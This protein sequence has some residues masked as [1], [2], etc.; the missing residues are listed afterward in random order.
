MKILVL[1]RVPF[2]FIG[3]DRVIDHTLHEVVYIGTREALATLPDDLLCTRIER[4]AEDDLVTEVRER[5]G[6]GFDRILSM[7]GKDNRAAGQLRA[8]LDVHGAKPHDVQLTEDKLAMKDAV[9]AA[10]LRVPRYA[11][12][13]DVLNKRVT[14]AWHGRTILK[15]I[16]QAGSRGVVELPT[17]EDAIATLRNDP[18]R[19]P[20]T[21]EFEEFIDAPIVH[22]DGLVIGGEPVVLVASRYLGTCLEYVT[23]R[24]QGSVQLDDDHGLCQAAL[25]YLAATGIRDGVFH[26]EMFDHALGPM[27]LEVAKRTGGG[28]IVERIEHTTGINLTAAQIAVELD[29]SPLADNPYRPM[30]EGHPTGLVSGDFLFP[31]H[32]LPSRFCRVV[33]GEQ[34]RFDPRVRRWTERAPDEALSTESS[35]MHFELPLSGVVIGETTAEVEAL[36][37]EILSTVRIESMP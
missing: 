17:V 30:L 10:G 24:P 11:S 15:P 25:P 7:S 18:A 5:V 22:L 26:L 34:L 14:P 4:P 29:T 33:G 21:H 32:K 9:V 28:G 6:P 23:G 35:Y 31:G 8:D 12:A 16:D 13:A 36:L 27:F 19:D 3:Y 2:P 20:V 1:H 37:T